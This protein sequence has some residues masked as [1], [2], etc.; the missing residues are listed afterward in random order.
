M[1]ANKSP[2]RR[3]ELPDDHAAPSAD[4]LRETRHRPAET[5]FVT[6]LSRRG[7]PCVE[8]DANLT[9]DS[10]GTLV[11]QWVRVKSG[12]AL[13]RE[14]RLF[15]ERF[16]VTEYDDYDEVDDVPQTLHSLKK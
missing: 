12:E 14:R 7:L 3:R 13:Q 4:A 2:L 9:R 16:R 8:N 10:D 15:P 11:G 6:R 5:R 1:P